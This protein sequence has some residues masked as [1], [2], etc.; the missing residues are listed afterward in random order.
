ML[1]VSFIVFPAIKRHPLNQFAETKV[2]MRVNDAK[3]VKAAGFSVVK[4]LFQKFA[5]GHQL[6]GVLICDCLFVK[7]WRHA[8]LY[9]YVSCILKK[10]SHTA[11]GI[12]YS[13]I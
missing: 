9:F 1:S 12:F 10:A 13:G 8:F 5:V 3:I 2:A 7:L 6:L 11:P 4:G